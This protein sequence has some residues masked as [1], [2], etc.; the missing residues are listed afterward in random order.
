MPELNPQDASSSHIRDAQGNTIEKISMR[1]GA[2]GPSSKTKTLKSNHRQALTL[3]GG[4]RFDKAE[5]L[6]RYLASTTMAPTVISSVRPNLY[7]GQN[8]PDKER[9]LR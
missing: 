7:R 6:L 1:N 2:N 8:R 9:G 5:D 4:A 3:Y